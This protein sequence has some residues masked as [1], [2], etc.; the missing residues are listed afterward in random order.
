MEERE[1]FE[2]SDKYIL[3]L[4]SLAHW[5]S[6]LN[7]HNVVIHACTVSKKVRFFTTTPTNVSQS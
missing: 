1:R 2:N 3:K 7:T 6:V 5:Q 4:A